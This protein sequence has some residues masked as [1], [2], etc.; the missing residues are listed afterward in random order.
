MVLQRQQHL[1]P[2]SACFCPGRAGTL[3][4]DQGKGGRAITLLEM[5][6]LYADSAAAIRLRI[7]ELKAAER[8]AD[9]EAARLL[10]QRIAELEPL[11]R[12]ARELAFRTA[13]YYDRRVRS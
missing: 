6:V 2:L 4:A 7:T 13:H 3:P 10:R 5:S 8:Q 11:L 9:R 1:R 12:D